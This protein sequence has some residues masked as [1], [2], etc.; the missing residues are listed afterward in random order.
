MWDLSKREIVRKFAGHTA[1]VQCLQVKGSKLVT[2][3][4]D[5]TL[6]IWDIETGRCLKTLFGHVEG[7][8]C[9]AFDS[10]RIISGAHDRSLK[11]LDNNTAFEL[12]KTEKK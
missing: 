5:N 3:S 2:G 11:V 7:V 6:K 8:W 1:Q 10:L 4:L 9:L 12:T